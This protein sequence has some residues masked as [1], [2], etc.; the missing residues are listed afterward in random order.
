[1]P[2]SRKR[3]NNK[4]GKQRKANSPSSSNQDYED[5]KVDLFQEVSQPSYEGVIDWMRSCAGGRNI[6][7]DFWARG[8][9]TRRLIY[10]R[11]QGVEPLLVRVSYLDEIRWAYRRLALLGLPV[12][13]I[14]C[15]SVTKAGKV[16]HLSS[17]A[18]DMV[19]DS[20]WGYIATMWEKQG[21]W[22]MLIGHARLMP[23][24]L[25]DWLVEE[26]SEDFA[27]GKVF[28]A[29]AELIGI[30]PQEVPEGFNKLAGLTRGVP[31][32]SNYEI[33][34]AAMELDI[35]FLDKMSSLA[36][37]KFLSDYE[38]ELVHFQRAFKNLITARAKSEDKLKDCLDE[39]KHEIAEL[40]KAAKHQ[41]IRNS[42]AKLGGILTTFTISYT[43]A[44]NTQPSSISRLI[45]GA[46]IAAATKALLDLYTQSTEREKNLVDNPYFILWKLGV[47]RPSE[48]KTRS[49]VDIVKAPKLS[50]EQFDLRSAHHWLCPPTNGV[51]FLVVKKD[52]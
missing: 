47:S 16:L 12:E 41:G 44:V 10:Q 2:K 17:I 25:L 34:K 18:E 11:N 29:P 37:G 13:F 45:G 48:V 5:A 26:T 39:L 36:F 51:G 8:N 9:Y 23:E 35:P 14:Y 6:A 31:M 33:A 15:G 3:K 21:I 27:N 24:T 20:G 19:W 52:A 38:G 22:A 50:P 32:I 7:F 49:K 28:V 42:V 43:V 46:G 1:M 30:H 4:R 40:T